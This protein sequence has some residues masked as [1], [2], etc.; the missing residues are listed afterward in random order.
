MKSICVFL[1]VASVAQAG[2]KAPSRIA[3]SVQS[4]ERS[5]IYIVNVDG[6]EQRRLTKGRYDILPRWSPD[7]KQIA[8]LSLRKQDHELAAE[9]DLAFHWFLYVM[10][11]DGKNEHRLTRAPIGMLYQWS[12]DGTQLVF[13]SSFE[14]RRNMGKDGTVSSAI[15]VMKTD[16][17]RQ[18]R[19]TP[20]EGNDGF[21]TWSPD[22]KQISF[23]SN[24]D[25]NMDIF[26]MN[27]DGSGTKRLTDNPANDTN[28]IWSP[29]GKQIA[30]VSHR[31]RGG[32]SV[33]VVRTDGAGESRLAVSG[34]PLAWSPDGKQLL[35]A[36]DGQIGVVSA[37]GRNKKQL[38]R[39]SD[40]VLDGVFSP[41]G[42]GVFYR[43]KANGKWV[44]MAKG[45]N[46][47]NPKR[48]SGDVGVVS[49]FSV[50]PHRRM[51]SN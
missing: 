44:I 14:D 24:R 27:S 22:G 19:L 46:G 43:S 30:F 1:V 49:A 4:E 41:D 45:I 50:W 5:G 38:T 10:D 8:F 48:I 17:T 31:R 20:I 26:V 33:S 2:D 51:L 28:P 21:P 18:K 7:G 23:C 42:M 37:D 25:G 3:F 29:D 40:Q 15:Y 13:E 39:E 9:H 11:A 16:G 6:S 34:S 32:G 36:S 47:T 12:P 35:V